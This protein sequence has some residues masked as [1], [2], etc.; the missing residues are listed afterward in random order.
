DAAAAFARDLP[1]AVVGHD[2]LGRLLTAALLL[3][4]LGLAPRLG[5]LAGLGR[6]R[7]FLLG[8]PPRRRLGLAPRLLFLACLRGG[9]LLLG[10]LGG[11]RCFGPA[12]GILLGQV[13][14]ALLLR[15]RARGRVGLGLLSCR[16]GLGLP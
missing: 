10:L 11:G 13:G 4:E 15:C 9:S 1:H 6:C 3:G 5:L 2:R 14:R 12:P 8:L 16:V 7:G